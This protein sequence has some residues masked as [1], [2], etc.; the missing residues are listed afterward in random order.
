VLVTTRQLDHVGA[1]L[2]AAL[3]AGAN[4][5]SNLSFGVENPQPAMRQALA[6]AG[7]EARAQAESIAGALGVKLGPVLAASTGGSPSPVPPMKMATMRLEAAVATPIEAGDQTVR[8]TLHVTYG[9]A[10][11]D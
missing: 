9:I 11:D 4:R 3:D 8:A 7:S 1:I 5:A 6:A 2:D 10:E